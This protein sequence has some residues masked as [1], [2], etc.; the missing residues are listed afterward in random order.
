MPANGGMT[1]AE[2][3]FM[4]KMMEV[5]EKIAPP[6]AVS[7]PDN[8]EVADLKERLARLEALLASQAKATPSGERRA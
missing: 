1:T 3:V 4:Q 2:S 7:V 5:F 8:V 6:H